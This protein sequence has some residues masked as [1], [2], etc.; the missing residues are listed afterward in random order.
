MEQASTPKYRYLPGRPMEDDETIILDLPL[1]EHFSFRHHAA[2]RCEDEEE[3]FLEPKRAIRQVRDF[4]RE[5]SGGSLLVTGYR[6]TGKSSIV[7]CALREQFSLNPKGD[8]TDDENK[9]NCADYAKGLLKIELNLST[10]EST[11][12]VLFLLVSRLETE[13]EKWLKNWKESLRINPLDW[14]RRLKQIRNRFAEHTT[15]IQSRGP[16][17]NWN[18]PSSDAHAQNAEHSFNR[19]VALGQQELE[20]FLRELK[21]E[22]VDRNR[23]EKLLFDRKTALTKPTEK[24]E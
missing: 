14:K 15:V 2:Y 9:A 6:G 23:F 8:K 12:D 13:I 1:H 18:D 24:G 7:H 19:S 20:Q 11:M 4:L 17:V 16:G 3:F 10:I 5:K 21:E 22:V